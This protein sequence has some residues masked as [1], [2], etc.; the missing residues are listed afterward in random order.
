MQWEI[1][2]LS[3][4]L[5]EIANNIDSSGKSGCVKDGWI[6]G[7]EVSLFTK[8]VDEEYK[9]G[10]LSTV[11]YNS[12][13]SLTKLDSALEYTCPTDAIQG[14]KLP[15]KDASPLGLAN[16]QETLEE[17]Y[18]LDQNYKNVLQFIDKMAKQYGKKLTESDKEYIAKIVI[19]K[20]DKYGISDLSPVIV[21][22]LAIETGGYNF[23]KKQMIHPKDSHKGV[24]QVRL[25]ECCTIMSQACPSFID[26]DGESRKSNKR[27]AQVYID[28]NNRCLKYDQERIAEI[29][30]KYKTPKQLYQAIQEDVELGLEVGILVFK[31]KLSY[32]KG[33]I[34]D[35]LIGYG[36][37]KYPSQITLDGIP[38]KI[39]LS[40]TT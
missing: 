1:S 26:K 35:G 40:A 24:M 30:K 9:N 3:K 20:C 23:T 19:E 10:K 21:Q 36:G 39:D 27:A 29:K 25:E 37:K 6:K 15:P 34:E 18:K 38:E 14:K 22:M 8:A 32:G 28:E 2:S 31:L 5:Q 4:K 33:F 16:A 12:V 7:Q 17:A 11:E 13:F